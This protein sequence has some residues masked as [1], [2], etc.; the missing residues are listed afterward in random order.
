MSDAQMFACGAVLVAIALDVVT[1]FAKALYTQTVSSS[2]MREGFFHK[3]AIIALMSIAVMLNISAGY[4][5]I[6]F[7]IPMVECPAV[8]LVVMELASILENLQTINPDLAGNG[9]FKI[10]FASVDNANNESNTE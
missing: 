8:Y 3:F 5:D 6:G 9:L 7:D 4:F 1:G 2:K 10:L